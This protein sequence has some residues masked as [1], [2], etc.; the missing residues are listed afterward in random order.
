MYK[1]AYLGIKAADHLSGLGLINVP[2][3]DQFVC[4]SGGEHVFGQPIPPQTED[5]VRVALSTAVPLL[6]RRR[7]LTS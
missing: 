7:G 5:G 6:T 3:D 1:I 2:E 4:S